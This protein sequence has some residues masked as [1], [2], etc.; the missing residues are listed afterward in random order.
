VLFGSKNLKP[1]LSLVQVVLSI[2]F[3]LFIGVVSW[4]YP[5]S[6]ALKVSPLKAIAS[7]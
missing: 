6:I 4:I 5:V 3:T 7:E 2:G 1:E